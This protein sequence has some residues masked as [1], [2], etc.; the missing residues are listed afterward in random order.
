M[1]R[2][3]DLKT[4]YN[5][6]SNCVFCVI[7]DKLFTGDRSTEDCIA[8]LVESRKTCD[9]VV[10]TGAEV[11]IRAD[12]FQLVAAAKRLG[13][14]NIQI[15]TNGRMFAY[16]EFC[17][18][19][20]RAGANEFSPSIHGHVAKLHDGLTRSQGSFDQIV[21]AMK[22]LRALG[23]RIV[24]NTVATRQNMKHLPALAHM[25][26][27][28]GVAQ[29]QIAFPHPT[30]HAET[31]FH[32]VVPRMRELAPH[33]HAALE[34]G[35]RAGVPCMA[36]AM[37]YCTM[38]GYERYVSELYIPPT[39]IVYDG[40][41]VPDY[42]RDRVERGKTR[43]AQCATCRFEPI[44]EGPWREYPEHV[45]DAEFRPVA[46]A[47]VVDGDVVRD[48][49]F[50]RLGAPAP[51]FA[52][53]D[54]ARARWVAVMFYPEAFSPSCTAE[55]CSVEAGREALQRAG[56]DV[57]GVSPDA[58]ERQDA[59]VRAHALGFAQVSDPSGELLR[60]YDA[61]GRATFLV[62]P[63]RRIDHVLVAPDV[64]AHA[65]Q[66]LGAIRRFEAPPRPL[67]RG[68]ELVVIRRKPK[69]AAEVRAELSLDEIES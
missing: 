68:A 46:G 43:F 26:V 60:A 39:E 69:P 61:R 29:Y 55:A 16:R 21:Q 35:V 57:I 62:G 36:E 65:Q 66:I 24:T 49:R 33:I 17:E 5:C 53:L 15:Q 38:A 50:A 58:A 10:F 45:G 3:A 52:A 18:R 30:G 12:F 4:G 42:E 32:G 2:R 7:G 34:V 9:D 23:Q 47:R 6:N 41:V 40:F 63:E 1:S 48:A 22:N 44:C 28:L 31:Y 27:E 14:R 56:V 67:E 64:R 54:A 37:P 11:T 25:L 59:F 13:Y 51:R 8:E 19:A 20:V